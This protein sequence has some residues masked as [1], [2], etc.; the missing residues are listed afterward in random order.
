MN[1]LSRLALVERVERLN[2]QVGKASLIV[3]PV[4]EIPS[5]EVTFNFDA[6]M[7]MRNVTPDRLSIEQSDPSGSSDKVGEE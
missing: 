6:F 7:G 3:K 1:E 5:Y 2:R 4:S